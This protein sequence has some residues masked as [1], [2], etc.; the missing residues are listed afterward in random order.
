M[1][2]STHPL[3]IG[4]T[5]A[6]RLAVE[7]I[8]GPLLILAGPGS[9]KT[10]VITHR[11]AW[12]LEQGVPGRQILALTFT[13]KAADEMRAR[14]ARLVPDHQVWLGTFHRFCARLLRQ[15]APLV[16]LKENFTIYDS[17]ASLAAL[18]AAIDEAAESLGSLSPEALAEQISRRK[19]N[20]IGPE[21]DHELAGSADPLFNRIYRQYARLLLRCNAVD[22]DD[23]LWYTA[24]L[25]R[26]H[27]EVR[28]RLDE[29]YS[30]V[31]V[32]EYQD[33]NFAQYAIA[34][35]LSIDQPNLAV[36]GD[37][38]QSIYGWRGANLRNI[39][40]FERDFPG[41]RV[42]RLEQNY[43]ST[44]R[45]LRVA[46][47]LIRHNV[48]RKEKELFTE[49]GEGAPVRL[50]MHPTERH[51]A[52]DIA[53]IIAE[54]VRS[55]KRRYRDFAV[56]YRVNAL[57]RAV[58]TALHEAAIP[59]QM[60]N[61]LAFYQRK[62]IRDVL[63]YLQL[64]E[65]PSD[66]IAM[67]RVLNTP[68]RGIGKATIAKLSGYALRRGTTLFE[69]ARC[70]PHVET[71]GKRAAATLANFV[72]M[73]D[74]LAGAATGPLEELLGL[75]LSESGY[76]QMLENSADPADQD[77]LANI[78]E[79][80]TV[81]RQFD[82]KRR[83]AASLGDF[84]EETCLVNDTDAW[85]ESADRVTLMTLHA[86][87]GL[88]FPVV[89]LI[90]VE[91]GILPHE[92][93]RRDPLELEEERRLM[94]VG[95]TR[96]QEELHI[97]WSRCRDFRGQRRFTIP[98]HFLMELPRDEMHCD[99][100]GEYSLAPTEEPP[101]VSPPA[102]DEPEYTHESP[103]APPDVEPLFAS[104][105]AP[106]LPTLAGLTTA[107]ELLEGQAAPPPS[108]EVFRQ[109]MVVRHPEFG[110]GTIVAMS[111]AGEERTATVEFAPKVGRQRITIHNSPLRPVKVK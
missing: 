17:D 11:I 32:D 109:G 57:S 8:D 50:V 26:D 77:R 23:L 18:R 2:S 14:V 24:T 37:P 65:N 55:G 22:F 98:S 33:T 60:V 105:P 47:E 61:G 29:R 49:N 93:G 9:G 7:T 99:I 52:E 25:L 79:L 94:F 39:L 4:L 20:L 88:E 85:E 78:E 12:L 31:M 100:P 27:P 6:Q 83:S 70:A 13:N 42:I 56:F 66:D 92:R 72:A 73:V 69:A 51:E 36:T 87:K 34:R 30:Y 86:S 41:V 59:Y 64:I 110:L 84:L 3:L 15:Y 48:H 91:E 43:R 46:S 21:D 16:G 58:E 67:L 101:D 90:A 10:R 107:A 96:A 5:P 89:F 45:I 82:E 104:A 76:R 80:L 102:F 68:A 28:S 81:A 38:D 63:S 1:T 71:L 106:K 44:Q 97:S 62:E 103:V 40:D 75:V 74:R 53:R 111:G 108:P 95:L 19:N 54:A 35:S